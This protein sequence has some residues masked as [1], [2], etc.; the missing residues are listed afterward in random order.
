[1][2]MYP[3]QHMSRLSGR[4]REQ[5]PSHI[6]IGDHQSN[7]VTL[8]AVDAETDIYQ[9]SYAKPITPSTSMLQSIPPAMIQIPLL[10]TPHQLHHA[11]PQPRRRIQLP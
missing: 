6:W 4:H 10:M 2:A 5:A 11:G 8:A 3:N 7:G 1:M 9:L